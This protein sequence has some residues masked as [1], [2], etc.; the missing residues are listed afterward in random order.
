MGNG[1]ASLGRQ[2][3]RRGRQLWQVLRTDG[4]YGIGYRIRRAAADKLRPKVV[5][6][7]VKTSDVVAADLL[8]PPVIRQPKC[9][10]GESIQ[11][12]WVM[13]PP[14]P[15]SGGH[16]TAFRIINA[17]QQRGYSSRIYFDD[18]Y[19]TDLESYKNIVR[20]YYKFSGPVHP[21]NGTMEDAHGVFATS[22]PTAYRVFNDS[23]SGKRFYFIQDYEPSF[24]AVGSAAVLAENT[25]RMGFHGITAGRWLAEKMRAEF[26][27]Q[28]D[29]FD[30]GCDS[31]SY[32]RKANQHRNGIAFYAKP[33]VPRRGYE[34]G[35]MALEI[36]AKRRP[37]LELHFYGGAIGAVPFD[38]INHGMVT[39]QQLSDIYNRCR[40]GLSLSLTNVSLVPLEMLAAGCIPVVNDAVH[41]RI[42]LDNSFVHYSQAS[43]P[44]L[45]SEL[46]RLADMEGFEEYSRRASASVVSTS[47]DDAGIAVDRVLRQLLE[48]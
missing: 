7:L 19:D 45:A 26:G 25:Y 32:P 47:W 40:A 38:H 14:N 33:D 4:Q 48:A 34:L 13:T 41:N 28:A 44:A 42:V 23:C 9:K 43:P 27:M 16:T 20:N 29:H 8:N 15:G 17:L 30:F 39:T 1:M 12:N 35:L 37:K 22:W 21:M 31:A 18:I 46:E 5:H 2:L 6:L 10:P 24:H 36:L 3:G 11:L